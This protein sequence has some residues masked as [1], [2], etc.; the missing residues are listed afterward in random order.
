MGS[1]FPPTI[2]IKQKKHPRFPWTALPSIRASPR[3]KKDRRSMAGWHDVWTAPRPLDTK[4]QVQKLGFMVIYIFVVFLN[5]TFILIASCACIRREIYIYIHI[6]IDNYRY[7]IY[8]YICAT[9]WGT[10]DYSQYL[11]NLVYLHQLKYE[12]HSF[13]ICNHALSHTLPMTDKPMAI[14]SQQDLL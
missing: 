13:H 14:K 1:G 7:L 10:Q 11:S 3:R 5:C 4:A 12:A 2:G 8:I 9:I 6:Y